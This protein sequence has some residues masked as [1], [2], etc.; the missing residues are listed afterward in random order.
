VKVNSKIYG[1]TTKSDEF[2]GVNLMRK[3]RVSLNEAEWR[4]L[5]HAMNKL[6][7]ILISEGRYTDVVD[8]VIM[9]FAQSAHQESENHKISIGL[10]LQRMRLLVP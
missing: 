5:L 4:L 10:H 7:I 6:R 3:I 1:L 2:W 8:E 9:K